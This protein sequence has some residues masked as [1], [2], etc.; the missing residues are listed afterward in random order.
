MLHI[1]SFCELWRV[2]LYANNSN[3]TDK[4]NISFIGYIMFANVKWKLVVVEFV[5]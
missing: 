5:F 4:S 3:A 2:I 1:T